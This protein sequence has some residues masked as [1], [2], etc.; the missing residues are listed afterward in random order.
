VDLQKILSTLRTK[1]PS[2]VQMI[3]KVIQ[4]IFEDREIE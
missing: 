3:K 2:Q 1:K 4:E